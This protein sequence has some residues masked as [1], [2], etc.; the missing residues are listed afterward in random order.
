MSEQV[1]GLL[2]HLEG[3]LQLLG[4]GQLL[5]FELRK[6]VLVLDEGVRRGAT[7]QG[8]ERA[9]GSQDQSGKFHRIKCV[10]FKL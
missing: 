1:I 9:T 2:G 3:G 7:D 6:E 5:V 4:L 8:A 10:K